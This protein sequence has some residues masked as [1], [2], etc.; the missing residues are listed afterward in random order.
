MAKLIYGSDGP[1]SV[2]EP[3][4]EACP[5]CETILE[6]AQLYDGTPCERCGHTFPASDIDVPDAP[7]DEEYDVIWTGSRLEVV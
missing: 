7:V 3:E 1:T 4:Y 5:E 6:D 2:C